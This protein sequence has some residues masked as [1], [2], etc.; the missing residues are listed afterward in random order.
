MAEIGT[1]GT[2]IY[3]GFIDEEYNRALAFPE[4]IDVY[5]EMRKSNGTVSAVLTGIKQPIMNG[6]YTI[7]PASEDAKDIEIAEFVSEAL[8]SQ[9]VWRD[10]LRHCLLMFDFG[11]MEFEKVRMRRDDGKIVYKKLAPRLPKS[12]L[13]WATEKPYY[14]DKTEEPGIEQQVNGDLNKKKGKVVIP[15]NK[16]FRLT[17]NQEGDNFEGV[18]I[19]R[20]PYM[21]WTY[22]MALYKIQAI[23]AERMGIGMPKFMQGEGAVLGEKEK[24]ALNSLGRGLRA[25][26]K[27]HII[28]PQG[29]DMEFASADFNF[30]FVEAIG[31]HNREIAKSALIQFID[32]GASGTSGGFAQV[33]TEQEMFLA[34]TMG[35]VEYMLDRMQRHLVKEL[36]DLNYDVDAYPTIEVSGIEKDDFTTQSEAISKYAQA[37]MGFTDLETQNYIRRTMELPEIEEVEAAPVVEQEKEEPK[38]VEKEKEEKSEPLQWLLNDD[39]Y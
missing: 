33:S 39:N 3:G 2:E 19:L 15:G 31:M 32:T 11:F 22:A 12:I 10:F 4:S 13:R 26:E 23:G 28:L 6:N 17:L 36:V 7:T 30:D 5:D 21:H 9:L 38:D 8:F 20:A 24:E 16:L 29:W 25:N 1:T 37:G 34:A 18:S 14:D 27:S 35:H